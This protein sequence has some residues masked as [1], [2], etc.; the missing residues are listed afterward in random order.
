MKS[1]L[2]LICILLGIVGMA[3]YDSLQVSIKKCNHAK[4]K[5]SISLV[6]NGSK[7]V[8]RVN[9]M[10]PLQIFKWNGKEWVQ[11]AMVGY[12]A[13]GIYS[14]PPPP[15]QVP[16]ASHDTLVFEWDQLSG[17]CTD[18]E[19]GTK[20]YH[21]SGRGK[22]KVVFEFKKERYGE[23]IFVEQSFNIR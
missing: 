8:Q 14:C 12:C 7:E 16:F 17:I 20:E 4:K 21:Y 9:P 19:K 5:V 22:Y 13:C 2:S 1:I 23:S 10:Q 18:R 11:V 15:E 6:N 3:Q